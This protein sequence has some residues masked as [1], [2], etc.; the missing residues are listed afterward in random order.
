MQC[1]DEGL[2]WRSLS[3]TVA[4]CQLAL[5]FQTG[6]DIAGPPRV[7][8]G[9]DELGVGGVK[10]DHFFSL[11]PVWRGL[12]LFP[13]TQMFKD[14]LDDIR[15][16]D[17]ADDAHPSLG[18]GTSKGVCFINFSDEVRAR[19]AREGIEI[20]RRICDALIELAE[21]KSPRRV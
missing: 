21:G 1:K 18:F 9:S 12:G 6:L 3:D 19:R 14:I 7:K 4:L 13:E 16:V 10:S 8:K 17:E 20:E 15:L 5:S 2:V 11:V